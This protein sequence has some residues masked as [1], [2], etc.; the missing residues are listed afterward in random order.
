MFFSL[1]VRSPRNYGAEVQFSHISSSST[2]LRTHYV[3]H[4]NC[5]SANLEIFIG[6]P[7][8]DLYIFLLKEGDL[9]ALQDFSPL[10]HSV[11]PTVILVEVPI[12]F[13]SLT[14]PAV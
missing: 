13:R 8:A 6:R 10:R 11:I 2:D 3:K 4:T 5:S 14:A 1:R 9:A 12:A 7:K